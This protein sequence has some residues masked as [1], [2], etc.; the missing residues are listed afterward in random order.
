MHRFAPLLLVLMWLIPQPVS[1][2]DPIRASV[3]KIH[4]KRRAPDL[5]RP[6]TKQTAS[7]T[8]GTG[9][10]IDGNRILTNAHVVLYAS[11]ITVQ[12]DR[13]TDRMRADVEAIAPGIDLA[14]LKLRDESLF[15]G[16]PPL[17]LAE[18]YP[19]IRDTVNVYGFPIG[20]EQLSVTEGII[21]RVEHASYAYGTVGLRIQVDAAL[22][23]GNSGG[24]AIADGKIAGL[25]FSRIS[26]ADNI[27]YLIPTDEIRMFLDDVKDGSYLGKPRLPVQLQT[28]ENAALRSRLQLDASVGGMM[29]T[30]SLSTDESFPLQTWDVITRVGDQAIDK[31]GQVDVR[32]DL[33]VSFYYLVSKMVKEGELPLTIVRN[34][35]TIELSVPV[36]YRSNLL[37]PHLVGDYPRHFI[38]GPLVFTTSS[39]E[40][41]SAIS[42][43]GGTALEVFA[44]R[45]NPLV[46][47]RYDR[48]RVPGEELVVMGPR[49]PH[50]MAEGYD[51]QL[52]AVVSHVNDV[53]IDNLVGL[54]RAIR[55][56]EGEYITFKFA[57]YYETMVFNRQELIESTEQILEDEGIRYQ[58]SPELRDVWEGEDS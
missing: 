23:P 4:T 39:Q 57:G 18:D 12:A 20:G 15:E 28:V 42:R 7:D 40:L 25:V 13:S 22:N 27:G 56:A 43:M 51:N 11:Q 6:W 31:Q 48:V 46:S 44:S 30:G 52:F 24:P 29:V 17:P 8:S 49:F 3:V 2:Q 38:V 36:E 45:K 1:A 9:A 35:K 53:R 14:I 58:M 33:R 41:V 54:V 50:P 34:G 19:R 55:E 21:S 16:R 47:R 37:V 32:D 26:Q 10:I 5:I